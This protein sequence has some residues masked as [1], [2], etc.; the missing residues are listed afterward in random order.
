MRYILG[1]VFLFVAPISV[2]WSASSGESLYVEYCTACH[3]IDGDGRV[4]GISQPARNFTTLQSAFELD[5]TRIY[6]SAI[7]GHD[8]M[9]GITWKGLSQ[10][11]VHTISDYVYDNFILKAKDKLPDELRLSLDLGESSYM[12]NCSVCH[13]DFGETGV[14]TRANMTT[15]PR[16]FTTDR[17]KGELSRKRMIESITYGRAGK[18]MMAYGSRLTAGEISSIADYVRLALMGLPFEV[19]LAEK[20]ILEGYKKNAPSMDGVDF[21]NPEEYMSRVF[22]DGFIGDPNEGRQ[23]YVRNCFACHGTKGNGQGPRAF[24]INPKPRNFTSSDSRRALNR[25]KIYKAVH[26]G[27]PG[28]VMPAWSK[29][30]SDQEVANVAEFVFRAFIR[31][32]MPGVSEEDLRKSK[33]KKN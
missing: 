30:L 14:W 11:E 21:A 18:A 32:D 5:R 23:I 24:F 2:A 17:T 26:G 9:P 20:S 3:G 19:V 29:V 13:G 33:Q 16:N 28:S 1:F 27:L 22:L 31:S 4:Q 15:A 12:S 6:L 7:K 10:T 25:Q 8:E